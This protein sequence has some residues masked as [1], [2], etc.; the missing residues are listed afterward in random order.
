V[1]A[2]PELRGLIAEPLYLTHYIEK[3]G[4]GTLDMIARCREASLPEPDFRQDG[5][6]WVII[7]WRDWLTDDVIATLNL[8][9]R[10]KQAIRYLKIHGKISNTEYQKVA[11]SIK[12]TAT[13]DLSDLKEKGIIEQIGNR[14]PGVH[15]VIAKKRDKKGTMG[16]FHVIQ[17]TSWAMFKGKQD[18]GRV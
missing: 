15:Y 4:T 3:A 18:T 14:G 10:Q 8:N 7:L 6:Q 12:K 13:R 16:T 17:W 2:K 9:N 1:G 11:N 5:G